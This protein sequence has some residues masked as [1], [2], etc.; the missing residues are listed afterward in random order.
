MKK[1]SELKCWP[2]SKEW[3][4]KVTGHIKSQNK[5]TSDWLTDAINEKMKREKR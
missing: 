1:P 3:R 4:D 5:T 2:K